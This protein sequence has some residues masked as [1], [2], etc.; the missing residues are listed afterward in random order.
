M[1]S[2]TTSSKQSHIL[3]LEP[4]SKT[5]K[6][7]SH[8]LIA[9]EFRVMILNSV[10]D[11]QAIFH[12]E[13]F[14]V[15]I[16]DNAASEQNMAD[17]YHLLRQAD[18]LAEILFTIKKSNIDSISTV[19]NL[20]AHSVL[21]K[22]LN[23]LA[24][25]LQ[26]IRLAA[27][28]KHL[29]DEHHSLKLH[30][31]SREESYILEM[32]RPQQAQIKRLAP[33]DVPILLQGP[34]GTGK[35]QLARE[36]H[37]LSRRRARP[38]VHF[39]CATHTPDLL[40]STLLGHQRGAF[41]GAFHD[42]QGLL[43]YAD[44]GTLYLENIDQLSLALQPRILRA[45][46]E[47]LFCRIGAHGDRRIDFRLI[48]STE[49]DLDSLVLTGDFDE[50]LYLPLHQHTI[51]LPAM[52]SCKSEFP[53]T[54]HQMMMRICLRHGISAKSLTP[55]CMTRLYN[56][57]WPY[58]QHELQSVLEY[59]L[60]QNTSDCIDI[61]HLPQYLQ[62]SEDQALPQIDCSK[63]WKETIDAAEAS[64]RG[65]YL[66]GVMELAQGNVT[67]AAQMAQLDRSNFRRLYKR[68]VTQSDEE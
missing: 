58:N 62:K 49:V 65:A 17:T 54:V 28:Y 9:P 40:D 4:D 36:I 5:R 16:V 23:D 29:R 15:I 63:S 26:Q 64:I 10:A 66:K 39:N 25:A 33:K 13:M 7:W 19:L 20:G 34:P 42:E 27:R 45:M 68:F 51:K 59:A 18:P 67:K 55:Q 32:L 46:R 41:L 35:G 22:P 48:A 3:V 38:F 6:L 14:D 8:L 61:C 24:S 56:H 57:D 60:T 50:D 2:L 47:H 11:A 1:P 44:Q 31:Q 37:S 52:A 12:R 30:A 53:R 21:L 43:E